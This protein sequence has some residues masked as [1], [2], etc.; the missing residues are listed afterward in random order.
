LDGG[1]GVIDSRTPGASASAPP[2][3]N[4]APV[5]GGRESVSMPTLDGIDSSGANVGAAGEQES[6]SCVAD[7]GICSADAGAPDTPSCVPTG[8]RDCASPLDN[9]CDGQLDNTP[10]EVCRC[11]PGLTEACGEHPGLDGRGPCRAG[12]RTCLAGPS[13]TSSD[14][15][16]CEGSVGPRDADSCVP[17]DDG[18]CDGV[19]NENCDCIEG[20]TQ[21]GGPPTDLGICQRGTQ[22]CVGGR[23]GD[24]VGA[25]FSTPRDCRSNVDN[26]CDGRLDNVL[27]NVCQC[28]IGTSQACGTHPQDGVGACRSGSQQCQAGPNN[29]SSFFSQQCNGASD[30]LH[31]MLAT[32]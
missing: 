13:N 3:E 14:W 18:D 29:S 8:A 15:S 5:A 19:A 9:D 28:I 10:D 30:P 26:D 6:A 1:S 17:E 7:A 12:S 11:A 23:F 31:K 24:C 27:D 21:P 20:A 16:T 32:P 2:N 25:T 22:T 4:V